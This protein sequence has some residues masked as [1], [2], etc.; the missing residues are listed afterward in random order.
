M[1][2]ESNKVSTMRWHLVRGYPTRKWCNI[3]FTGNWM[4]RNVIRESCS[5]NLERE[6]KMQE[7][8]LE[9][10]YETEPEFDIDI[11]FMATLKRIFGIFVEPITVKKSETHIVWVPDR[12]I[13]WDAAE[14]E[15]FPINKCGGKQ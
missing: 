11:S 3:R 6:E 9:V 12:D 13:C 1:E 7:L 2:Q 4:I 15:N 14:Y 8:M 5:E 10:A